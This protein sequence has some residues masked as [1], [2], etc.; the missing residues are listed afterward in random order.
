M[1]RGNKQ[2]ELRQSRDL[3]SSAGLQGLSSARYLLLLK[4][5]KGPGPPKVGL[6][7]CGDLDFSSE[8]ACELWTKENEE[9][10]GYSKEMLSL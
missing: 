10:K 7:K 2:A 4:S 3:K 8:R 5:A 1:L 9:E 6:V